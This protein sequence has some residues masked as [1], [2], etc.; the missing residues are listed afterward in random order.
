MGFKTSYKETLGQ[1][2]AGWT[3]LGGL[4]VIACT[5]SYLYDKFNSTSSTPVDNSIPFGDQVD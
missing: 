3:I 5:V 4:A 1:A 2:A